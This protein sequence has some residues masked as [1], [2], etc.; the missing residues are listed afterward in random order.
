[1]E[2]ASESVGLK[3]CRCSQAL[4]ADDIEK[5]LSINTT[6]K[7]ISCPKQAGTDTH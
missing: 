4:Q 7:A 1:M 2:H 6:G 5:S 3:T